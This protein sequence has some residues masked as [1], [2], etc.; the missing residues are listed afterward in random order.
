MSH[1]LAIDLG[2]TSA[3][4]LI[5]G[6]NGVVVERARAEIS[7][8]HPQPT[9]AEANANGW[10][11]TVSRLIRDVL[12]RSPTYTETITAVGISGLMHALVP[13]DVAGNVLDA[14]MLW[15]DQRCKPQRDWLVAQFG[16]R[17]QSIT[18]GLPSTTT[19]SPKLRWLVEN[20]QAVV[21]NTHCFLL[22]KDFI[23]FRLTGTFA[24]D[25]S[26]SRGTSL[27]DQHT[28]NW[29]QSL[30][31]EIIGVPVAKLPQIRNATDIAGSVT[32]EAAA[33]TGLRQGTPVVVGAS[34][35]R[36]T[37]LGGNAYVP[38]R[39]YLYMGTA[40]WL[41]LSEP[42]QPE[43]NLRWLGATATLGASLRWLNALWGESE[44]GQLDQ[45][46][47]TSPPGAEGLVFLP[48]LMGERSPKHDPDAKGSFCGLTLA[49]GKPHLIRAVL[50]GN[51]YLIRHIIEAR[52]LGG[53]IPLFV[54]GGG[55]KSELWRE[56]LANVCRRKV[57]V[58][59]ELECA[60]LGAAM[61]AAVGVGHYPDLAAVGSAWVSVAEEIAPEQQLLAIYQQGY[62][63]Y[64]KLDAA[65]EPIWHTANAPA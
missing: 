5:V 51:A 55:A 45:L 41:V 57:L 26:D 8:H 24:T 20:R 58:P 7:L 6:S 10:W 35:V 11:Q 17:I 64:R 47:A 53:S 13:V 52:G 29:S 31:E 15:M 30:V 33:E 39:I 56:I 37:Q 1:F 36:S 16:E 25:V 4:V 43:M 23:R 62:Q 9:W 27:L 28:G 46:A 18:D 21:R 19:S 65:L 2:T 54:M 32:Q 14:P 60:G 61:V 40:A 44:Y 3:K 50:E 59:K 38:D 42:P 63:L 49:H 48:H 22:P 34:D 12:H